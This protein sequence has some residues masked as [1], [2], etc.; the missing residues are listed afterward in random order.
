MRFIT[1]NELRELYKKKPFT[2]Y[3]EEVGVRLTPG[4]RQFLIDRGVNMFE[5]IEKKFTVTSSDDSKKLNNKISTQK[6]EKNSLIEK[7]LLVKL[8]KMELL[9]ISVSE[10]LLNQNLNVS[11]KLIELKHK[12]KECRNVLSGTSEVK[13]K[14]SID[15]VENFETIDITE[16]HLRL[17]R[18]K[19]I[20]RLKQIQCEMEELILDII[21]NISKYEKAERVTFVIYQSSEIIKHLD[22]MIK[23]G[24]GGV[25]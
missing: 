23:E 5:N 9:L 20:L 16:T 10:E 7:Q 22:I 21:E 15:N 2:Q 4:A 1:E 11:E 19:E 17:E 13:E 3:K 18:G 24:I 25:V 6:N 8:K 14:V 12:L